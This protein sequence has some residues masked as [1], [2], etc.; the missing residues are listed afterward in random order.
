[1]TSPAY[2]EL[3]GLLHEVRPRRRRVEAPAPVVTEHGH[4]FDPISGYCT[5]CGRRDTGEAAEGSQAWYADRE[6][7]TR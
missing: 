1:M 2:V 6:R 4:R 5:R 7:S 3:G